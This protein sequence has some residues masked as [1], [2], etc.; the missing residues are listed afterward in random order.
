M[1]FWKVPK[2]YRGPKSDHYDGRR[3][4]NPWH[5]SKPKFW[6]FLKWRLT[7]DPKP[8]PAKVDR[9]LCDI[10]PARVYGDDLRISFVGHSTVL[11][12]TQGVNI[13]TDPVW[14]NSASPVKWPKIRRVSVPGISFN[15]LPQIDIVLISHNHYD[16]LDKMTLKRLWNRDKP[17]IIAP[18]GNEEIIKTFNRSIKVKTLDWD[19]SVKYNQDITIHLQPAQHWSKRWLWDTNKALWGAFVME[20]T[21]G[22]IYFAGDTGYGEGVPFLKAKERFKQF[23][24]AM[25]PIGAYDPRRF[26][27]Y[28]HMN[29]QDAVLAHQD[30]GS[31]YTIPIHFKTFRLSDEGYETPVN[32]LYSALEESHLDP[33]RFRVLDIGEHWNIPNS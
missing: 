11:V 29:P 22:N 4:F 12:Q 21:G 32:L 23:R 7:A 1:V 8:W 33:Q 28:V 15:N 20:T 18:L 17:L 2:Y 16:H 26:M 9:E 31:P 13:L 19:Q 14:T 24:F 25:L 6:T 3:F 10:P 27:E 5:P 30:L